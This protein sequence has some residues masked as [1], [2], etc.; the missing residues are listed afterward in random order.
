MATETTREASDLSLQFVSDVLKAGIDP[1]AAE[2]LHDEILGFGRL[3]R[4]NT[5][6]VRVLG[7]W[8][9]RRCSKDLGSKDVGR[10]SLESKMALEGKEVNRLDG[11]KKAYQGK[12][13]LSLEI[14]RQEQ[15]QANTNKTLPRDMDEGGVTR[16]AAG[17]SSGGR[18]RGLVKALTGMRITLTIDFGS[19]RVD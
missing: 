9:S 4:R 8:E 12:M 10:G 3:V 5:R 7:G 15:Q 16:S 17:K 2:I 6:D 14:L 1:R 13:R 19:G 11:A 18:L